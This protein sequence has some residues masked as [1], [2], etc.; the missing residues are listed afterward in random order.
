[1]AL[2]PLK[3][4]A[5]LVIGGLLA[6][7]CG[8]E[9]KMSSDEQRNFQQGMSAEKVKELG[10]A[11]TPPSGALPTYTDGSANDKAQGR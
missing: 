3:L 6:V 9:T 8:S 4:G 1:M 2:S 11:P 5:A 7:G 10:P